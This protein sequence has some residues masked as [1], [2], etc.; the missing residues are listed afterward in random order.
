MKQANRHREIER[1]RSAG[2]AG[3]RFGPQARI[4]VHPLTG[5]THSLMELAAAL[6]TAKSGGVIMAAIAHVFTISYVANLLGGN[7][8]WLF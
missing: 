1:C 3:R 7:E 8:D 6:T 4:A 5:S 2:L